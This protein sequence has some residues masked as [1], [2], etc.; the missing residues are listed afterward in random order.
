[1]FIEALP[2]PPAT[3]PLEGSE[4][5][6]HLAIEDSSEDFYVLGRTR[7]AEAGSV[8]VYNHEGQE[9]HEWAALPPTTFSTSK[10]G[11]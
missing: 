4:I 9:P 6:E 5:L 7:E 11:R 8:V 10:T 1:M 3:P 2:E